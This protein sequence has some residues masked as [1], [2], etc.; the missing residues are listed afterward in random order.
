MLCCRCLK[1]YAT[2]TAPPQ[3]TKN[4]VWNN[5]KNIVKMAFFEKI[6]EN[7]SMYI[8]KETLEKFKKEPTE[9]KFNKILNETNSSDLWSEYNG[10]K[11]WFEHLDKLN[12]EKILTIRIKNKAVGR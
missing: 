11:D 9:E 8:S 10:N 6:A 7:S 3:D 12:P 4:Y 1:F 5:A 2:N